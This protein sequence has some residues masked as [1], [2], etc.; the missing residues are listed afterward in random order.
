MGYA[1]RLPTLTKNIV[2]GTDRKRLLGVDKATA[3]G[4]ENEKYVLRALNSSQ[5]IIT[6][7]REL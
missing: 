5:A 3:V 6:L 2:I 1:A 7:G 4:M